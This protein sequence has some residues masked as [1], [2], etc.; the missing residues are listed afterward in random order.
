[1]RLA[2]FHSP[3]NNP[4]RFAV[5]T[6]AEAIVAQFPVG[7]PTRVH[8]D[9]ENPKLSVLRKGVAGYAVKY[10]IPLIVGAGFVLI[11]LVAGF[12]ARSLYGG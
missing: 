8:V 10:A 1:M 5:M 11:G 4:H 12:V 7:L 9:P 3:V 2:P 6:E